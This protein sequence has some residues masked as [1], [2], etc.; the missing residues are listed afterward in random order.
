M[1]AARTDT[2]SRDR[3]LVQQKA[4]NA[5]I[6]RMGL[7]LAVYQRLDLHWALRELLVNRWPD[8]VLRQALR[9]IE[10]LFAEVA[11]Q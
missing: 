10:P 6:D 1:T 3:D 11:V 8:T 9:Q 5:L 4:I 2:L 7:D